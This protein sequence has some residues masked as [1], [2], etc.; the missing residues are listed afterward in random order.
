[1]AGDIVFFII[2]G[3]VVLSFCNF[4]KLNGRVEKR[5]REGSFVSLCRYK[6]KT[7]SSL[8]PNGIQVSSYEGTQSQKSKAT[9][10]FPSK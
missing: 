7:F 3:F 5:E 1:M 10:R 6:N 4:E 2:Y 9:N 8:F